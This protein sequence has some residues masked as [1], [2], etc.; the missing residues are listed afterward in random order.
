MDLRRELCRSDAKLVRE[1]GGGAAAQAIAT[2]RKALVVLMLVMR[3]CFSGVVRVIFRAGLGV[4]VTQMKRSIG[5]AACKRQRQQHDQAAQ[6]QGSL[7][8][9]EHVTPKGLKGFYDSR[10]AQGR[11]KV[12]LG[13]AA[14]PHQ[15]ARGGPEKR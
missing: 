5:V 2:A 9:N 3:R 13:P 10:I 4:S 6:E 7:Y 14:S 12:K 8:C 11:L 15:P 1:I